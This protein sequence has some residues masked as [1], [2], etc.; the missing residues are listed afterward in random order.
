MSSDLSLVSPAKLNLFLHI[1]GR[2]SDGYHQL[3]TLFQLLDWG[4]NMH[5]HVNHSGKVTLRSQGLDIPD[6]EN[7]VLRAAQL[8]QRDDWGA[9]ITLE[10]QV[11]VQA[12]F[13]RVCRTLIDRRPVDL[14]RGCREN[15]F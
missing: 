6:E 1:T 4:D 13:P 12:E 7:L 10:K 11:G 5:F 14:N 2:R 3:Q 8:L 15:A 9:E